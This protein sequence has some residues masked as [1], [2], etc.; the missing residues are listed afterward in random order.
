M[1]RPKRKRSGI[2]VSDFIDVSNGYLA[3]TNEELA[4]ASVINPSVWKEAR[5]LLEYSQS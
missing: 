5:Y 3:L 1:L 4:S 2:M